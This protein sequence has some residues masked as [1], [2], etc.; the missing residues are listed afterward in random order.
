MGDRLVVAVELIGSEDAADPAFRDLK[1]RNLISPHYSALKT[2]FKRVLKSPGTLSRACVFAG[3]SSGTAVLQTFLGADTGGASG[4]QGDW[5][6]YGTYAVYSSLVS[7]ES[8]T[9]GGQLS[10]YGPS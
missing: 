8:H 10:F 9:S 3:R 6:I 1:G 2:R 7:L 5:Y 4:I